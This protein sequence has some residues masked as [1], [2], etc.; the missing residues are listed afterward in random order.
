MNTRDRND[1][2]QKLIA[3]ANAAREWVEWDW[4]P[5]CEVEVDD[6]IQETARR[7]QS[8]LEQAL[9]NCFGELYGKKE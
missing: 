2:R 8:N 9:R 1:E 5:N 4:N 6:N 3:V 7:L